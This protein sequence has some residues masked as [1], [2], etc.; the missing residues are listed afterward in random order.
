MNNGGCPASGSKS[1]GVV[2][3][4]EAVRE[5]LLK[6]EEIVSRLKKLHPDSGAADFLHE[7]AAERGLQL[8][9]ET[10]LDIGNHILSAHFGVSAGDYEEVIPQLASHGVIG[11]ALRNRLKGLGGFRNVLV[12]DYLRIDPARVAKF[13]ARA[14]KDFSDFARAVRKWLDRLALPGK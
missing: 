2:L 12:H 1:G 8:G 6:L 14:P 7:W 10:I 9:A 4:A 3:R 13:L 5:R 11:V